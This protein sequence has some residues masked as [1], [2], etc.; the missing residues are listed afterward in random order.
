MH[1]TPPRAPRRLGARALALTLG[2]ALTAAACASGGETSSVPTL[3]TT[4]APAA[5]AD[6]ASESSEAPAEPDE[7][8]TADAEGDAAAAEEA[9]TVGPE[10][11]PVNLFPDV[12]VIDLDSGETINLAS[13]LG[14]GDKATLLWFW[15][16]H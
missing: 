12:N 10:A 7:T 5:E 2:L 16:P 4:A 8:P 15:A 6:A 3:G 1:A 14:G 9:P 13:T 11:P